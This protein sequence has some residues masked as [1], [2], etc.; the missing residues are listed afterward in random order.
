MIRLA[1]RNLFQNKARLVISVGG[2]SLA[3]LL[4]LALDAIFTGVE[5]QNT[6]YIDN[7]GADI[8]VAQKDV[9]NMHMAFSSLPI[10]VVD[11]VKA[12][13]G[14]EEVTP[15]LYLSNMI[16]VGEERTLAYVIGLPEDASMGAPWKM[17][18]GK[19][20]PE[21]GEAIID[22]RVAQKAGVE[23]GDTVEILA[24]EFTVMG[25]S[26]ETTNIVNSIAFI[27]ASDFG[28]QRGAGVVSY[29]LVRTQPNVEVEAVASRI[30]DEVDGVTAL[31]RESFSSQE[32]RVVKD[33]STDVIAIMN[34]IG[35][36][37]GSA[38][39]ALTVYTAVLS[40]R[41]E[42]GVLKALGA[43]NG[44]LYRVVL[45]QALMSVLLGFVV[46]LAFT[47]LIAAIVPRLGL[48]MT[49]EVSRASL[50][51]VGIVSLVITALSAVLPIRQIAGL[52]PALVFRGK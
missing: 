16:V 7:S 14:V 40:R 49:L 30:E 23:I 43:R 19:A 20:I 18:S 37:I 6:A 15:I 13:D 2:V 9:R 50:V 29:L 17:D 52:D 48:S 34:S 38:V 39:M 44:H 46:G 21:S 51:K 27:S 12:V 5:R 31:P 26:D 32:A 36:L 28:E 42:F 41:R 35:F 11:D 3:L 24:R 47:L 45:A 8:F 10:S 4:I 22:R 33:M 1:F 25:F